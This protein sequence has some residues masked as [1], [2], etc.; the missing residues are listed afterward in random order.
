MT[1]KA[2]AD[3]QH[4]NGELSS[5]DNLVVSGG[6]GSHFHLSSMSAG[7]GGVQS[8]DNSNPVELT[9]PISKEDENQ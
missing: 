3:K 5:M 4:T 8:C 1:M 2:R 6:V 7:S 9:A